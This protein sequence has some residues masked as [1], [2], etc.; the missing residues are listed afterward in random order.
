M[1]LQTAP[2][3]LFDFLPDRPVVIETSNACLSSD[4]GLLPIRQLDERL[5]F[6]QQLADALDDPRD[7]WIRVGHAV[8]LVVDFD[9]DGKN[10]LLVG[11]VMVFGFFEPTRLKTNGKEV[12]VPHGDAGPYVADPVSTFQL[13]APSFQKKPG[14]CLT[15]WMLGI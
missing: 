5:G 14:I 12:S 11:H 13:L 2:P 7:P 8:P 3:L 1:T 15:T 6:T 9:G 4:A 10:D